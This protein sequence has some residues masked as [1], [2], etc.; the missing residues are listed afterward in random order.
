MI[1]IFLVW[2][3]PHHKHGT[4]TVSAGSSPRTDRSEKS[5]NCF[6]SHSDNLQLRPRKKKKN[7]QL[8]VVDDL[9]SVSTCNS[10]LLLPLT[11]DGPV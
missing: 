3:F 9:L 6:W 1:A 4:Q 2:I 5:L 11:C 8:W 7:Q 10:T